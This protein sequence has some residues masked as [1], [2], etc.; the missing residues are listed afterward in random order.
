MIT[1]FDKI[2]NELSYKVKDG[3]PNL[4]NE[5]HLI[6]LWDVLKECQWPIDSRVELIRN[7]TEAGET[8]FAPQKTLPYIE[9][10]G[11]G[12]KEEALRT[13]ELV[14]SRSDKNEIIETLM[15]RAE[16]HREQ[17]QGMKDAYAVFKGYLTE[18]D[19]SG[20]KLTKQGVLDILKKDSG[21]E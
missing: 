1:D 7:L 11:Y 5:Q 17:T 3:M 20:K 13:L 8:H 15:N 18:V 21:L 2:L 16:F 14:D 19:D 10:V 9:G 12:S 4:K 6:K